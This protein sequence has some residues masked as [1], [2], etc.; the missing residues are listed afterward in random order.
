[1]SRAATHALIIG[2]NEYPFASKLGEMYPELKGLKS[3]TGSAPAAW[4]VSEFLRSPPGAIEF[5]APLGEVFLHLSWSNDEFEKAKA[6]TP[7][8]KSTSWLDA[9]SD[10]VKESL[11]K[12]RDLL[13]ENPDNVAFFFF[14][15]HGITLGHGPLLLL[16]NAGEDETFQMGLCLLDHISEG[17]L[18]SSRYPNLARRQVI[19]ADCCLTPKV[20]YEM[21][22]WA[23]QPLIWCPPPTHQLKGEENE[24][25]LLEVRAAPPLRHAI[26]LSG[27]GTI[28]GEALLNALT[29]GAELTRRKGKPRWLV[30]STTLRSAISHEYDLE[31]ARLWRELEEQQIS[32]AGLKE[33]RADFPVRS[34]C[35]GHLIQPLAK[36]RNVDETR[37]VLE[38][39]PDPNLFRVDGIDKSGN[40]EELCQSCELPQRRKRT[41]VYRVQ[42][43]RH[44]KV[45][46]TAQFTSHP[47]EDDTEELSVSPVFQAKRFSYD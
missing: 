29:W 3:L 15:G 18:P 7:G 46:V 16:Q 31:L 37:V 2:V 24:V 5:A 21:N 47:P 40:S 22:N 12:W 45:R 25:D 8:A 33:L 10:T 41:R 1:V 27:R 42:H 38:T 36:L 34:Q 4:K 19:I 39:D 11:L 20:P 9:R 30:T 14:A 26:S 43:D 6:A 23:P 35:P 44:E 13:A 28:L 17:L 32:I